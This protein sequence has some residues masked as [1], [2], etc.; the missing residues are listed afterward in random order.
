MANLKWLLPY[1]RLSKWGLLSCFAVLVMLDLTYMGMIWVQQVLIDNVFLAGQFEQLS[2]VMWIYGGIA[3][4]HIAGHALGPFTYVGSYRQVVQSVT[5]RFLSFIYRMPIRRFQKERTARFVHVVSDDIPKIADLAV[6]DMAALL[7]YVVSLTLLAYFI[8]REALSLL[9]I[10]LVISLAYSVLIRFFHPR[11]ERFGKEV[12][13]RKSEWLVT[14]EEGISSTREVLAFER[15]QWESKRYH[16]SFAHYFAAVIKQG[17]WVNGQLLASEPLKWSGLLLVLGIGGFLVLEGRLSPG[18]FV[19]IYSF[20]NQFMETF[21]EGFESLM[22]MSEKFGCV[23]RI[24]T[25]MEGEQVPDGAHSLVG[26]IKTIRFERVR[27]AYEPG[28]Q[29]VLQDLSLSI[30]I[31]N[32]V[33]FVGASGGGK[34]TVANLL[35]RFYEPI[36]GS[37]WVNGMA[38]SDIRRRDWIERVDIV[39]QEPYLF[40]DTLRS[41]LTMGRTDIS[42]EQMVAACQAMQIHPV[43]SKLPQGYDS[44]IGERGIRLSGGQRQRL[45]LARAILADPEVLILDESTSALDLETERRVQENLDR[46]RKGRTTVIIAHRLSTVQNA[47]VIFVMDRGRVVEQG[48]YVE[49]LQKSEVFKRLVYAQEE[50]KRHVG[51]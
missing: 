6:Y 17:K 44:T 41:N 47:D 25:I 22:K 30:P 2:S 5:D 20:T 34:S 45:A 16:G 43:F 4:L 50:R 42:D 49:L 36:S 8:G 18:M 51:T 24:R 10:I 32:K 11:L 38:L 29:P 35:I 33:A 31:G 46:I 7:N 3:L 1:V 48:S 23:E 15:T 19:V 13:E 37:I 21:H 9:L 28:Q 27:F 40:P 26:P 39:F 14:V 12:Q